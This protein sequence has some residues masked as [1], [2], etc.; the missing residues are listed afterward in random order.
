MTCHLCLPSSGP[1][2]ELD[3][4]V[5]VGQEEFNLHCGHL[6]YTTPEPIREFVDLS[7]AEAAAGQLGSKENRSRSPREC[8][9]IL[10]RQVSR[11]SNTL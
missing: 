11:C 3:A 4:K 9:I 10:E 7:I 5:M 8:R 1:N 2:L 6:K